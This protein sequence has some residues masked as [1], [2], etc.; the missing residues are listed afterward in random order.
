MASD[1]DEG[2]DGAERENSRDLEG[3]RD[4]NINEL[5]W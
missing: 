1:L 4:D 3:S 2:S 5:R